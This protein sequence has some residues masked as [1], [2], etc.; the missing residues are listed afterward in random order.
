LAPYEEGLKPNYQDKK[1]TCTIDYPIAGG[2]TGFDREFAKL[3]DLSTCSGPLVI[4]LEKFADKV[5][6]ANSNFRP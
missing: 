1:M 3:A 6:E 5:E 4:E 2:Q